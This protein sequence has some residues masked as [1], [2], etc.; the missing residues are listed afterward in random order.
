[1]RTTVDIPDAVLERA[2]IRAAELGISLKKF[3]A[4]AVTEKVADGPAIH[5]KKS[6]FAPLAGKRG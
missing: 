4:E 3:V 5:T 1:M 6:T 2:R